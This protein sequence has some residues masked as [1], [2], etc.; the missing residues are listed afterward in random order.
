MAISFAAVGPMPAVVDD[1]SAARREGHR[2]P[3][4]RRLSLRQAPIRQ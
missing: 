4:R 1:Y 3:G 2:T